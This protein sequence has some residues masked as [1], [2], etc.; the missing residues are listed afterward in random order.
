MKTLLF[1]FIPFIFFAKGASA[2]PVFSDHSFSGLL[3]IQPD[4]TIVRE[5][6]NAQVDTSFPHSTSPSSHLADHQVTPRSFIMPGA[7]FAAGAALTF[8]HTALHSLD[9][10]T[11]GE[12]QEDVTGFSTVA[13]NF[14]QFAPAI[15]VFGLN[16]AG[17]K[18]KHSI[19]LSAEYYILSFLFMAGS[20]QLLKDLTHVE[21][22]DHSD[23]HSFPSGHTANAFMGAEFLNQEY[24]SRS[25]W[26]SVA[27]YTTAT[28]TGVLR[29]VNNR[30]W[31]G[32]VVAGAGIGI[33]STRLSYWL[34]PK[35]N[36]AF[37]K[38]KEPVP[39]LVF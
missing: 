22:P 36:K 15:A 21:R 10:T 31:L 37:Q 26:Y 29:V 34:V 7:V 32:D 17:V 23:Y 3:V 18:G 9:S 30:H 5:Q 24:G 19:K 1:I 16:A 33:L 20:S 38:K 39:T 13:D 27:G 6:V 14:L 2:S 35:I 11:Q 4:T 25:A 12:I 28:V 8:G